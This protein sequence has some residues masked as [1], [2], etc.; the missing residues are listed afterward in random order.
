MLKGG[1]LMKE[2]LKWFSKYFKKGTGQFDPQFQ[3]YRDEAHELALTRA[4][5][6]L[7]ITNHDVQTENPI[8]L[9]SPEQLDMKSKVRYKVATLDDNTAELLYDQALITMLLFGE[10]SLFYYQANA[11]YRYGLVTNDVV[12]ELNYLDIMNVQT[13][14][15]YDDLHD[16]LFEIVDLDLWLYDGSTIPFTLRFRLFNGVSEEIILSDKEKLILEKLH[17]VIRTKRRFE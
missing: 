15:E 17:R 3:V 9:I 5:E 6:L 8:I 12:G 13:S 7:S 1:I 4:F 2:R 16:P 11:D 14:F 10:E